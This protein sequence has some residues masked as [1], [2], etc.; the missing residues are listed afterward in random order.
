MLRKVVDSPVPDT[1]LKEDS[2]K[3]SASDL[4]P[5]KEPDGEL[6]W[7][8]KD[9]GQALEDELRSSYP[10]VKRFN[11]SVLLKTDS[12]KAHVFKGEES[13]SDHF[14]L[15]VLPVIRCLVPPAAAPLHGN[16]Q[17]LRRSPA[18]L[19]TGGAGCTATGQTQPAPAS[20]QPQL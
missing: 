10:Q 2:S 17:G 6:A 3:A 11:A 8:S 4:L 20:L 18:N 1:L 15:K 5:D 13:T 16:G 12:L 19:P 14:L 7:G 9:K